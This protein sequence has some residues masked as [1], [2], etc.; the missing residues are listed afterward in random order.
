MG[1][2]QHIVLSVDLR[3]KESRVEDFLAAFRPVIDAAHLHEEGC[4]EYT[5]ARSGEQPNH[6]RVH[7]VYR[8][9]AALQAHRDSAHFR[10]WSDVADDVLEAEGRTVWKG[11]SDPTPTARKDVK[12]AAPGQVWHAADAQWISRGNGVRSRPLAGSEVG[13]SAVLTGMTEIPVGG[14]I[15]LHHHNTDEFIQVLGGKARVTID[16]E[17]RIVEAGD[18]T[19]ALPGIKHRYVNIGDE[20]L[21]ILWVYGDTSTTRTIAA[22]GVTLGHLDRYDA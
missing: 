12:A 21:K 5:L 11:T 6:F 1:S 10:S 18:S 14:E 8:D 19:L 4:L 9:E 2:A 16:G 15:P 3:V 20:P 22:T 17:D 7:E 13:A